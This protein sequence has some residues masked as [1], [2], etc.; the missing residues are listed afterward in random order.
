MGRRTVRDWFKA[1][2]AKEDHH[3]DENSTSSSDDDMSQPAHIGT[4][5]LARFQQRAAVRGLKIARAYGGVVLADAVGLGKTRVGLAIAAALRR[6]ARAHPTN[7]G[8]SPIYC[9]VP[10]RL[11]EQWR[12]AIIAAGLNDFV[13]V[14]HTAMSRA[15]FD[16]FTKTTQPS[17]ILVDEAHRFRNP[18]AKRSRRLA[19]LAAHAPLVLISATPICNSQWDLYHLFRLFLADH[20]LRQ[21]VGHNLKK[22]FKLAQTGDFDLGELVE[23]L[24]IRRIDAPSSTGFGRRPDVALEV[25]SYKADADEVWLWKNLEAAFERLTMELFRHD[26]PRHLLTEYVL[27]RW[28]SGADA[29]WATLVEMIDFHR[30]WL[31]ADSHAHH[32][33]RADFRRHFKGEAR[34]QF[35]RSAACGFQEPTAVAN[36]QSVFPFFYDFSQRPSGADEPMTQHFDRDKVERDLCRLRGLL[37]RVEVVAQ[38]GDDKRRAILELV[39][40][41]PQKLLIF[42]SYQQAAR[43]LFDYLVRRLGPQARIGLV[44]GDGAFATGLG[45]TRANELVRRFAPNSNGA[46]SMPA[47]QQ[48]GVLIGTDCL[49]EGVNLQD[50]SRIVLADLPYSPLGVEQRIGRLLRP[51]APSDTAT[52]YLPRPDCWADSLG[53]RRR[54]DRKISQAA[55]VGAN[56]VAARHLESDS[57]GAPSNSPTDN[58][59]ASLTRLDAL[60]QSLQD[61]SNRN[62]LII[63]GFSRA[64]SNRGS[65]RLWLRV[66]ITEATSTRFIWCFSARDQT[67]QIRLSAIID[68]LISDANLSTSLRSI[69]QEDVATELYQ[70]AQTLIGERE[71]LLRSARLAPYPLRLDAPQR[72]L[73]A[74][75]SRAIQTHRLD[76]R[77]EMIQDF[78]HDLLRSF[79]RGV[80]RRF[81]QMAASEIPPDKLFAQTRDILGELPKW[82]PEISLKIVAGLELVPEGEII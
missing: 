56:F 76:L 18:S 45:K 19:E 28:E 11:A 43:G 22:A 72:L 9:C 32:L 61:S 62:P 17:V 39:E 82:S 79:P 4:L 42:T 68:R 35:E 71:N 49:S 44:T 63:N 24:V 30:R 80:E 5:A 48:I 52:V 38:N 58:S 54:L 59:L 66:A 20:D 36:R 65:R 34:A 8:N 46:L 23:M 10:A 70:P 50:C 33:S 12:A 21:A 15:G 7:A 29:L 73:W 64:K 55:Y 77:Q 37:K 3:R 47:H 16:E 26:W 75:I 25:L 2:L 27:K 13:V 81:E 51:G 60:R 74:A 1:F 67:P 78:R 31:Q 41:D 40:K 53:L 6:D 69:R 57:V 14:T